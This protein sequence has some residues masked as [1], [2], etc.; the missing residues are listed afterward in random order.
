LWT[1]FKYFDSDNTGEITLESCIDALKQNNFVINEESLRDYFED[2]KDSGKKITF[3]E[4]KKLI[5]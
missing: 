1:A 3:D 2:I 4:F 5:F